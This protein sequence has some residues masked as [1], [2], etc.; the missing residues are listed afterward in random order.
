MYCSVCDKYRKSKKSKIE[1][2]VLLLFTVNVVIIIIKKY[3]KKKN[4]LIS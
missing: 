4:Q 3:L 1:T 2:K